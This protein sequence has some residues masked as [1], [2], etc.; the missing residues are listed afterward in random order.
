MTKRIE[1]A[2]T[3]TNNYNLQ[4]KINDNENKEI[5]IQ[6]KNQSKDD[7]QDYPICITF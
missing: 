1:F 6:L 3:I 5:N 2:I 4:C 7:S